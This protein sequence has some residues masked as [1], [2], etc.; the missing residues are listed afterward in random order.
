MCQK[1]LIFVLYE[2]S[3][4]A[5]IHKGHWHKAQEDVNAN[6]GKQMNANYLYY[7]NVPL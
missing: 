1:P 2:F 7:R 4:V 3:N 6:Q 5:T